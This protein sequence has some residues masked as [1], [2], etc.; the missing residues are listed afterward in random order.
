MRGVWSAFVT[1]AFVAFL[2]GGVLAAPVLIDYGDILPF[3][4][5]DFEDEPL[6]SFSSPG[7]FEYFSFDAVD[8][9]ITEVETVCRSSGQCLTADDLLIDG[10]R[11]F[12]DFRPGTKSLGVRLGFVNPDQFPTLEIEVVGRH[13]TRIFSGFTAADLVATL[14]VQDVQGLVSV[15][16]SISSDLEGPNGPFRTNYS[17]DDVI[18]SVRPVA[19]I[20]LPAGFWLLGGAMLALASVR[21]QKKAQQI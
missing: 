8:P 14:G 19:P 11:T 9:L 10:I 16:F 18:T 4:S 17:F 7:S 12:S 2:A 5:E 1:S 13:T 6:G 3:T 21:L 20:P 15:S